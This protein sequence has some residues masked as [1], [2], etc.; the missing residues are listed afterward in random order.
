[1]VQTAGGRDPRYAE[2]EG[3]V[4]VQVDR[5]AQANR[6]QGLPDLRNMAGG[7]ARPVGTQEGEMVGSVGGAGAAGKRSV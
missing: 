3:R 2:D 6:G 7:T 5:N 1:M 4:G